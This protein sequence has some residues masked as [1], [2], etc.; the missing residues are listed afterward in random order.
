MC[1]LERYL[2][3]PF[4]ACLLFKICSTIAFELVKNTFILDIGSLCFLI[5]SHVHSK[6]KIIYFRM[7]FIKQCLICRMKIKKVYFSAHLRTFWIIMTLWHR[8]WQRF[9]RLY[10]GDKKKIG[11]WNIFLRRYHKGLFTI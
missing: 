3:C 9:Y 5:T 2:N 11:N 6:S 1:L 8:K 7:Y 4:N 10:N